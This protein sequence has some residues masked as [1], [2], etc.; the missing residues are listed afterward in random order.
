[1]GHKVGRRCDGEWPF[2]WPVGRGRGGQ[3][4]FW[5]PCDVG[6]S[7]EKDFIGLMVRRRDE[8][9]VLMWIGRKVQWWFR[10]RGGWVGGFGENR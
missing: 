1:M 8:D 4:S 10:D 7:D 5:R 2:S 9:K 3:R 6:R